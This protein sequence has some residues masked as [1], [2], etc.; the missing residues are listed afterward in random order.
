M[1]NAGLL[2]FQDL[3]HMLLWSAGASSV[4]RKD[5]AVNASYNFQLASICSA[6]VLR[7]LEDSSTAQVIYCA[8]PISMMARAVY[9]L[10]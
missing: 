3:P 8:A 6:K 7:L 4:L 9:Q 2:L 5:S 10:F 1:L